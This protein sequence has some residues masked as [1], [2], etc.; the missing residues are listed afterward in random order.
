MNPP[1]LLC[2]FVL[3]ALSV[4]PS[5]ARADGIP[6]AEDACRVGGGYRTVGTACSVGA[7]AG[8]CRDA[9]CSRLDYAHW[10][11]DASASPPTADYAC[12]T[13]QPGAAA[14]DKSTCAVAA[15]GRPRDGVLGLCV[16]AL[17]ITAFAF[18]SRRRRG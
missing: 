18:A 14:A 9:T 7:T 13:C 1:R 6:P 11:R 8:V 17:G 10:D 5:L 4:A 3:L 16:V 12:V 2:A 15:T